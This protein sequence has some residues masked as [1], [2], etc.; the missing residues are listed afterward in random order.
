MTYFREIRNIRKRYSHYMWHLI[1]MSWADASLPSCQRKCQLDWIR[2]WWNSFLAIP[3]NR[4]S[5]LQKYFSRINRL[6]DFINCR[7]SYH[8]ISCGISNN[9]NRKTVHS[10]EGTM[11]QTVTKTP[12]TYN[13]L[14]LHPSFP[15]AVKKQIRTKKKHLLKY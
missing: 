8:F 13:L 6:T 3:P 14:N 15:S 12:Q 9:K 2:V 4:I 1:F 7:W 11:L 10:F 5:V